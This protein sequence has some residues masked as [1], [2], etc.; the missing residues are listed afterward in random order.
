M[1]LHLYFFPHQFSH[2]DNSFFV[3]IQRGRVLPRQFCA[4][5]RSKARQSSSRRRRCFETGRKSQKLSRYSIYYKTCPSSETHCNTL[6]HT[7]TTA[8]HCSALH[9]TATHCYFVYYTGCSSIY[10]TGCLQ[11]SATHC[12]TLQ[13]TATHCSTLQQTTT[14][15]NALRQTATPFTVKH[16]CTALQH[17]ATL[18]NSLQNIAAHCST[19]QHTATHCNILLLHLL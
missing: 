9:H 11:S 4:A 3:V 19:L 2:Q 6:Q 5:S 18:C 16:A 15:C 7:A 1:H 12:N 13:H 17:T 14:H 10:Y 8:T